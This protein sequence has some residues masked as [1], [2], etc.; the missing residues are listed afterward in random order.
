MRSKGYMIDASKFRHFGTFK[1]YRESNDIVATRTLE[2]SIP[3]WFA[4]AGGTGLKLGSDD[5]L[6]VKDSWRRNISEDDI[7]LRYNADLHNLFAQKRLIELSNNDKTFTVT[8]VSDLNGESIY[9][10]VKIE[11]V[12]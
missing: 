2:M 11:D 4:F 3:V 1:A 10:V 6:D 12:Q 9:S 8:S 5:S 7:I